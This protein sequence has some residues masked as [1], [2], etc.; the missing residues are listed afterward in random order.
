MTVGWALPTNRLR[1]YCGSAL[2]AECPVRADATESRAT[3]SGNLFRTH[4]LTVL[5]TQ[6]L[7]GGDFVFQF[8][9]DLVDVHLRR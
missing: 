1:S 3:E 5:R 7:R 2:R 4:R 8:G 9:V 6:N